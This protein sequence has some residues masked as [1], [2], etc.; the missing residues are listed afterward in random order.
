MPLVSGG[1]QSF[2]AE[3]FVLLGVFALGCAGAVLLG[4]RVRD[5]PAEVWV[6]RGLAVLLT[7]VM[8]PLQVRD[9][10]PG[11]FVLDT[12]L[13]V[14]LCDLSWIVAVWA[15]WARNRYAVALLYYWGLTLT[16]QAIATPSLA[17]DYPDPDFFMYWWMH[18][19]TVWMAVL[20]VFGLVQGPDWRGYRF[21]VVCTAAWAAVMMVLNAAAGTNFGYLRAKPTSG[22]ILDWFGPWPLYVLVEVVVLLG[23]WA[24]ITW[25][26][27]RRAPRHARPRRRSHRG[28]HGERAA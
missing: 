13:P 18:L 5:R 15:L 21:T 7:A 16:V 14:Q 6:R 25:P 3:H 11:R 9:L 17:Q 28:R 2:G 8:V 4:R 1:F 26:W 12:A 10:L 23:F 24:L 22:S 27:V 20:I 19:M